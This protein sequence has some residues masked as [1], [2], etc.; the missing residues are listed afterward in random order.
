MTKYERLEFILH[1]KLM[2]NAHGNSHWRA[3][4]PTIKK[5]RNMAS[6]YGQD[7]QE[8]RISNGEEPLNFDKFLVTVTIKPPTRRKLDPPN[9]YPTVKPIIDGLTDAEWWED[10]NFQHMLEVRFRYG[11]L[12][13]IKKEDGKNDNDTFKVILE[14]E[15]LTEYSKYITVAEVMD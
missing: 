14:I 1:R 6:E 4:M 9:Y 13:G 11:G 7:R 12:A 10:D 5:L 15:E 3:K 2:L 8:E